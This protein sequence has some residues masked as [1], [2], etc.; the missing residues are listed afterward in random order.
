ML[1]RDGQEESVGLENLARE[2]SL[3]RRCVNKD[4]KD[5]RV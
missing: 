3:Q 1:E 2:A 4:G 5:V